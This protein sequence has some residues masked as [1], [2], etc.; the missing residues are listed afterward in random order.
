M[1]LKHCEENLSQQMN[2]LRR[3]SQQSTL[4]IKQLYLNGLKQLSYHQT[5][6]SKQQ[7]GFLGEIEHLFFVYIQLKSF[8][9]PRHPLIDCLNEKVPLYGRI[10]NRLYT[11]S[12]ISTY[13]CKLFL[14]F[15]FKPILARKNGCFDLL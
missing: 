4:T 12:W 5:F 2:F 13:I 10:A 11:K 15:G 8:H 1:K 7:Q 9:D 6:L 14:Q 3:L